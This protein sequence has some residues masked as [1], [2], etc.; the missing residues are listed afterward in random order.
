[1]N[2]DILKKAFRDTI[3]VMTGYLALGIGFGV[4]LRTNGYEWYWAL[5]MAVTMFAGSMQYVAVELLATGAGFV[6]TLMTTLFVNARH[7]FYGISL[8]DKYKNVGK[9]KP[10]LIFG[11]TD[12]TYSLVCSTAD[13]IE[14]KQRKYYFFLVTVMDHCYWI[15][16]CVT[17][18]LLGGLIT[19]N[20]EG[21]D[22]VL[23]AL[24]VSIF[25]EQW[26]STREHRPALT[27]LTAS[28]VCLLIFGPENFL[29]PAMLSIMAVLLLMRK[30]VKV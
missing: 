30:K 9:V 17:G 12:E 18:A 16:G 22:F 13:S 2:K 15:T 11:L 19:F 7:L 27:G 1:M 8:V 29:I 21:I 28:T 4:I 25:V 6:T 23:T 24:F 20:T 14:P 10:Y 26:L 5:V 3:P